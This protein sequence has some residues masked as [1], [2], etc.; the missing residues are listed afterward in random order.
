M[1]TPDVHEVTES[2]RSTQ[3]R[4]GDL[5]APP[6]VTPASS[7]RVMWRRPPRALPPPTWPGPIAGMVA[8]LLLAAAAMLCYVL[9]VFFRA[10]LADGGFP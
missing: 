1:T 9:V 10:L 5:A 8:G 6:S 7:R 2:R 3:D 4:P